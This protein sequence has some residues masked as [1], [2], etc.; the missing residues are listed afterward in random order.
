MPTVPTDVSWDP[1][2]CTH[3]QLPTDPLRQAQP[4]FQGPGVLGGKRRGEE[5]EGSLRE[6]DAAAQKCRQDGKR[7]GVVHRR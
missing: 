1:R 3:R 6:R 4:S 5:R 2:K 7:L